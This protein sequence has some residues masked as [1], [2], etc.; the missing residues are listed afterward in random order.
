MIV[1][2]QGFPSVT[3]KW[4][5]QDHQASITIPATQTLTLGGMD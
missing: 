2:N 3:N 1:Q 5:F 4:P